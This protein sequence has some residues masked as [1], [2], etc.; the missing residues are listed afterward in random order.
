MPDNNEIFLE[1]WKNYQWPEHE[2]L[3]FR[4]YHDD[5]GTPIEYSRHDLPGSYVDVTPEQFAVADMRVKIK[6]GEIITPNPPKPLK[7]VPSTS[8]ICCHPS[9]VTVIVPIHQDHKKWRIRTNDKN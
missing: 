1:F 2:P 7:L 9:D 4:L 3:Y 5:D 8:G 6:N